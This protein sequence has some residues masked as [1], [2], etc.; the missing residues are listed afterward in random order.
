MNQ[1]SATDPKPS[2]PPLQHLIPEEESDHTPLDWRTIQVKIGRHG[3]NI[4]PKGHVIPMDW[5]VWPLQ[6]YDMWFFFQGEGKFRD[7]RGHVSNLGPGSCLWLRPGDRFEF[8]QDHATECLGDA[9][10]HFDLFDASGQ[11]IDRSRL[12]GIPHL[13]ETFDFKYFDLLSQRI[14]ALLRSSSE[15]GTSDQDTSTSRQLEAEFLL[16]A[17]LMDFETGAK[18]QARQLRQGIEL[19][20]QRAISRIVS[21]IYEKPAQPGGIEALA[22][23]SGYSPDY[24]GRVFKSVTGSTPNAILIE[25]KL[26]KARALLATSD[27][28]VEQIS[29]EIGYNNPFYFSRQFRQ[30]VGLSPS[31]YRKKF[32]RSTG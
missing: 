9:Y 14:I 5:F 22:Q 27:F 28:S 32:Q 2:S 12:A 18:A 19:R 11:P 29:S 3:R 8:W 6:D 21:K 30:K 23:A 20:H 15:Q 16:K 31:E 25:A 26:E 4:W 7:P 24:F 1:D 10:I 17:L 13:Y